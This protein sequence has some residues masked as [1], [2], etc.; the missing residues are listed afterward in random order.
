MVSILFLFSRGSIPTPFLSDMQF[1]Q[2]SRISPT[3]HA[4]PALGL[5]LTCFGCALSNLCV[6]L[7]IRC[8]AFQRSLDVC[9]ECPVL[10]CLFSFFFFL[11][12]FMRRCSRQPNDAGSLSRFPFS[13]CLFSLSSSSSSGSGHSCGSV[14]GEAVRSLLASE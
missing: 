3:C 8:D 14:S 7:V 13:V 11:L 2:N 5:P 10:F 9:V 4:F 1:H 6:R 12:V